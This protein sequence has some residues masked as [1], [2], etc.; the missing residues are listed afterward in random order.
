MESRLLVLLLGGSTDAVV[1]AAARAVLHARPK[2]RKKIDTIVVH[3][4]PI[5][6]FISTSPPD[7]LL[8]HLEKY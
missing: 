4:Y 6:P 5:I 8:E 2:M 7:G 3:Y 1:R